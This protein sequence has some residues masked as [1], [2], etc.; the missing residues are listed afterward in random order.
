MIK[1]P[2]VSN[3]MPKVASF[4]EPAVRAVNQF[5]SPAPNLTAAGAQLAPGATAKQKAAREEDGGTGWGP[6]GMPPPGDSRSADFGLWEVRMPNFLR[7]ARGSYVEFLS[8][9]V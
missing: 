8:G 4:F 2:T 3:Q 1:T 9:V 5:H 7:F 6:E